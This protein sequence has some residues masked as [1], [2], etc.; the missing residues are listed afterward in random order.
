MKVRLSRQV[1]LKET[2]KSGSLHCPA[3]S[4]KFFKGSDPVRPLETLPELPIVR[5][6]V[7]IFSIPGGQRADRR[8]FL[9]LLS[10]VI[11]G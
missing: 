6:L 4:T 3:A 8:R 2:C 9:F 7:R 11:L 1:N 10:N 5:I